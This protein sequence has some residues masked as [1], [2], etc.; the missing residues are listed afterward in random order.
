VAR[1]DGIVI[2]HGANC[3]TR[4]EGQRCNCS[5]SYRA[6][7]WSQEDRKKIW[8]TF[9]NAAEARAWRQDASGAIRSGKLRAPRPTTV[10]DAA[11]ALIEGMRE[12]RIRTR[13]GDL[14][15]PSVIRSYEQ[16]LRLYALPPL[17]GMRVSNVRRRDV[18][19][20]ADELLAHGASPSTIRNALMPLRVMFRRAVQDGD[21]TTSPCEMLRLPAVRSRRERISSPAEAAELLAALPSRLRIVY[22]CA[23]YSG[24]RAGELR[25][26][27]WGDIDLAAGVIHVERAMDQSGVLVEPKSRNGRRRVPIVGALRDLLL[28]H[29]ATNRV[30]GYVLGNNPS[31]PFTLSSVHRGAKTAWEHANA[32]R[33]EEGLPLLAPIGLH[34][35][36][37]TFAS[38]LIA[39]GVN[40]KAMTAFMGHAS[41]QT[42]F[43]L[44]GHL[45][46]GS[47]AEATLLIDDYLARADT[48]ARLAAIAGDKADA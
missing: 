21:I 9:K 37:H 31:T 43:D 29:K 6:W 12:G 35:A 30:D 2:R 17:G 13:S 27:R 36:R 40:A 48:R 7:V 25:A 11:E 38:L 44:Y 16:A 26:L 28:E 8:R 1:L 46:P 24:L 18:Q 34:E 23:F 22:G 39:A 3:R 20:V 14:Y 42:T 33:K 10:A 15:K 4:S 45:M 41:I 32:A 5:P 19:A 47:E